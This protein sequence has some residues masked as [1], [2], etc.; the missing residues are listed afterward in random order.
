[1]TDA[2]EIMLRMN[3]V[4]V[5]TATQNVIRTLKAIVAESFNG[6]SFTV[7]T[8]DSIV[9]LPIAVARLHER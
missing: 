3:S 4:R 1:M 6:F 7:G 5:A 9:N 2:D 8:R